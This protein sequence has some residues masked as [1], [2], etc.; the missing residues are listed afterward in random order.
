MRIPGNQRSARFHS[1]TAQSDIWRWRTAQLAVLHFANL[2]DQLSLELFRGNA[3]PATTQPACA[4]AARRRPKMLRST[5]ERHLR[6]DREPATLRSPAR[7][8][9]LTKYLESHNC[10]RLNHRNG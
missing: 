3:V 7:H 4:L 10:V 2:L 9:P 8:T 6:Q 5:F 1:G